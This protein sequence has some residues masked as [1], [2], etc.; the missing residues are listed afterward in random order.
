MLKKA[1]MATLLMSLTGCATLPTRAP[2][3]GDTVRISSGE[4]DL[5]QAR[6]T[7]IALAE[8]TLVVLHEEERMALPLA[9]LDLVELRTGTRSRAG[10]GSHIG[11]V[12]GFLA[13][14]G[15]A[16]IDAPG[17]M[18][19]PSDEEVARRLVI[20]GGMPIGA[21]LGAAVGSAFHTDRWEV[22]H[23]GGASRKPPR[24]PET[25]D[26]KVQPDT[27]SSLMSRLR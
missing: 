14:L 1:L 24:I 9:A 18:F 10:R 17:G 13:V 4:Q 19:G 23:R 3:P 8:D 7:F 22:M 15:A 2:V 12:I 26:P 20:L 16:S 6:A 21:L 27:P 11:S 5:K 25:G